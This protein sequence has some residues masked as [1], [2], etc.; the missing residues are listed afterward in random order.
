MRTE[1]LYYA[2]AVAQTG[3]FSKAAELLYIKQQSV[4]MAIIRLEEELGVTLFERSSHGVSLTAEGEQCVEEFMAILAIYER[5]KDR[6]APTSAKTELVIGTNSYGSLFLCRVVDAL[7]SQYPR[8]AIKIAEKQHPVA[9]AQS[10]LSGECHCAA[11]TIAANILA[12]D[13]VFTEHLHKTLA[14]RSLTKLTVGAYVLAGHPLSRR[15]RVAVRA[16]AKYPVLAFNELF[17]TDYLKHLAGADTLPNIIVSSNVDIHLSY[18]Q[19]EQGV[20]LAPEGAL[21]GVSSPAMVFLPLEN[22]VPLHFGLLYPLHA[23]LAKEIF[24]VVHFL[25]QAYINISRRQSLF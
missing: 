9:L 20:S 5:L 1:Q 8:L 6:A 4:R 19:R 24:Q 23:Q 11:T 18:I 10:I 2:L 17:I 3:S 22:D 25:E 16:L 13:A 7:V 14:F 12:E 21:S 15:Q